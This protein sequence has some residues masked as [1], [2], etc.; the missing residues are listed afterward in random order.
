MTQPAFSCKR[1][2]TCCLTAWFGEVHE[3]DVRSWEK[4]GRTDILQWVRF[5]PLGQ[6]DFAYR[7]W[8]DPVTNEETDHCPWLTRDLDSG[9]YGCRIYS[10]RP[11]TC[12]YFPASE[13]H[14][15]EVGCR[16]FKDIKRDH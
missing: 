10:V 11:T 5:V 13:N 2:G 1:C 7:V 3:E 9:R 4:G 12:R 6:D 16:G 14:A 8:V 15:R